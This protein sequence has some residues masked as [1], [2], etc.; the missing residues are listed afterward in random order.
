MKA[1]KTNLLLLSGIIL[2]SS[3]KFAESPS[4]A[5]A[6]EMCSCLFVAEQTESF[7][8]MVTKESQ[9]LANWEADFDRKEVWAKGMNFR[10]MARRDEDPRYGCQ[11][12]L[13]EV[14]PESVNQNDE[15]YG[16]D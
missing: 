5:L 9:I 6:K 2:F 16:K 1:F 14:D 4:A 8:R 11:I 13:V 7:C 10:S 3:C 12:Q 15:V